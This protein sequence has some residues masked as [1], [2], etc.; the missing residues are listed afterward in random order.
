M[1]PNLD[2]VAFD[3][4]L[5]MEIGEKRRSRELEAALC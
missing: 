2:G 1:Y 5:R 3:D 4:M